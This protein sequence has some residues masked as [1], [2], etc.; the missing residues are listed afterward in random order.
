MTTPVTRFP[1]LAPALLLAA[2]VS[3]VPDPP[4]A[5]DRSLRFTAESGIARA[6]GRFARWRV[7]DAHIDRRAPGRSHVRIEIDVASLET[8]M[9]GRDE[10]LRDP[11]FFE[12]ARW[13][14]ADVRVHG[15]A[16][17]DAPDHYRAKFDVRI[18]DVSRTLEGSFDVVSWEP[19][20]VS[21]GLVIDRVL[22]GVGD[23]PSAWNPLDVDTDVAVSFRLRLD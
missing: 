22:F 14:T 5:A 16:P 1:L 9:Q 3:V 23:A 6:E 7:V 18:R 20:V 15:A 10:H 13:P 11:D 8:G 12:V 2:C 17:G 19:L 4:E 21:G